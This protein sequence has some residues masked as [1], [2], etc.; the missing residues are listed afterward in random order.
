[1][2]VRVPLFCSES[3]IVSGILSPLSPILKIMNCQGW[4]LAA[5]SGAKTLISLID[6]ARIFFLMILNILH[7]LS[8]YTP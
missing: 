8:Y 1:M 5:I 4:A 6:G 3:A 7:L 2:R